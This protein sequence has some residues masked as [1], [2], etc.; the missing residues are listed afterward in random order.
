MGDVAVLETLRRK[1]LSVRKLALVSAV[2][3]DVRGCAS[4]SRSKVSSS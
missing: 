4:A 1:T 3:V 2:V